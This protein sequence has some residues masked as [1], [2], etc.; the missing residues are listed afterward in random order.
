MKK[1]TIGYITNLNVPG[2]FSYLMRR[3]IENSCD[4]LNINLIVYTGGF[5]EQLKGDRLL[6]RLSN[7]IY[8]FIDGKKIDGLII[9]RT[10]NRDI[11]Y[12]AYENFVYR[13]KPLPIINLNS[14]VN[15]VPSV[16]SA[17]YE[18]FKVLVD[19]MIDVHNCRRIV[20]AHLGNKRKYEQCLKAYVDSFHEHRLKKYDDLCLPPKPITV[21]ILPELFHTVNANPV[22]AIIFT[23]QTIAPKYYNNA[24]KFGINNIPICSYGI[25]NNIATMIPLQTIIYQDYTKLGMLAVGLLLKIINGEEVDMVTKIPGILRLGESCGCSKAD[26][27]TEKYQEIYPKNNKNVDKSTIIRVLKIL[28]NGKWINNF[29]DTYVNEIMMQESGFLVK[30]NEILNYEN[31]DFKIWDQVL[32]E[33]F[34]WTFL[35]I[36]GNEKRENA[37]NLLLKAS[38]LLHDNK[39]RCATE[40][41]VKIHES[42]SRMIFIKQQIPHASSIKELVETLKLIAPTMKQIFGLYICL[43]TNTAYR[44]KM[45]QPPPLFSKMVFAFRNGRPINFSDKKYPT[46]D[47]LPPDLNLYDYKI[48]ILP[49]H[50]KKKQFGF[51]IFEIEDEESTMILDFQNEISTALE[52]IFLHQKIYKKQKQLV[53]ANIKINMLNKKLSEQLNTAKKVQKMVLPDESKI[54][55]SDLDIATF[56]RPVET[57]S[58]DFYCFF[59][60]PKFN[61]YY[62]AIMDVSGHD[63]EAGLVS[64]M[65]Q[66]TIHS[67]LRVNVIE[68]LDIYLKL[69][70]IMFD[71]L[72]ESK[73]K[74]YATVSLLNYNQGKI[75]A[76]GYHEDII[77][78]RK[79]H[80]DVIKTYKSG[81][82]LGKTGYIKR[83]LIKEN[84]L[85][86]EQGDSMV[87]YTDGITE[88]RNHNDVYFTQKR[89]IKSLQ[90]YHNN[91][92]AHMVKG[93]LHDLGEFQEG[94]PADDDQTLIIFTK[95]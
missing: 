25:N 77:V 22:D 75:S 95:K 5:L 76:I 24:K 50:F 37:Y 4:R 13:Y 82:L 48:L 8:E 31:L 92:S 46:T 41:K 91:N 88:A 84:Y 38:Q 7:S 61:S 28:Y 59:K 57:L 15:H 27:I 66:T 45:F 83:E 35:Y 90:K 79:N 49:L 44:Y 65:I 73:I 78:I 72:N 53:S 64:L 70:Q 9:N 10:I 67:L 86:L 19:H 18:N 26:Q 16:V 74:K 55:I 40:S 12:N 43:Y 3:S 33:L 69:N 51:L 47:I 11:G 1:L 30:F 56:Y 17:D 63:I 20:F 6:D 80:V 62:F 52:T 85:T 39:N 89:L 58:G 93:V 42:Q 60:H 54:D 81:T 29:V 2:S 87:L 94:F 32:Y 21:G 23:S 68:I 36:D 71:T 34:Q 14:I